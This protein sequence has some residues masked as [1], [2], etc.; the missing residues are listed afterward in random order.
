MGADDYPIFSSLPEFMEDFF[1]VR[2]VP[3]FQLVQGE[4]GIVRGVVFLR[5]PKDFI[6][7]GWEIQTLQGLFEDR[8]IDLG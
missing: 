1:E 6:L 4:I 2:I 5:F 7:V 8:R 3:V